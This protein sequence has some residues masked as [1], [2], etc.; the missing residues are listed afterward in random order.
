[1]TVFRRCNASTIEKQLYKNNVDELNCFESRDDTLRDH[2]FLLIRE[3]G[4]LDDSDET[5]LLFKQLYYVF[6]VAEIIYGDNSIGGIYSQARFQAYQ[7]MVYFGKEKN[8]QKILM[9]FDAFYNMSQQSNKQMKRI[10][11]E[12]LRRLK[13]P[14]KLS[15]WQEMFA[16]CDSLTEAFTLFYL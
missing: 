6:R 10:F 14:I 16:S 8:A 4:Y 3:Y 5:F 12:K 2:F 13:A 7:V 9:Q 15:D 1:R 11:P